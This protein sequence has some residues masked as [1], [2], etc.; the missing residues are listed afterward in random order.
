MT[1]HSA[2]GS[3]KFTAGTTQTLVCSPTAVDHLLAEPV[4]EWIS[5]ASTNS[6]ELNGSVLTI[7]TLKTSH[8]GAYT[9][10]ARLSIPQAGISNLSNTITENITVQSKSYLLHLSCR[11][12]FSVFIVPTPVLSISRHLAPHFKCTCSAGW[13]RQH[14]H[15]SNKHLVRN[16]MPQ[17]S[18]TPPYRT[19]LEFQPLA[20]NSSGEYV[21]N[22]MFTPTESSPLIA[23]SSVVYNLKVQRK[24]VKVL[25]AHNLFSFLV[26]L[27][28]CRP[29]LPPSQWC[30][31]R[32][33]IVERLELLSVNK[34]RDTQDM[35]NGL[36]SIK[37]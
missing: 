11:V 19:S 28:P 21:L 29:F 24:H 20:T 8:A 23:S 5:I 34:A 18:S 12:P 36:T 37:D 25:H 1:I 6:T 15:H 35:E 7:E 33:V 27:Q 2:N 30:H 10:E 17:M 9:C 32:T 14:Q 26:I 13:K 16:G 31:L 22:V 4:V 3:F